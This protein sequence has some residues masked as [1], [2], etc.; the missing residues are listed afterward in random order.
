VQTTELL[1]AQLPPWQVSVSVQALPSLQ[2]SVFAS[3]VQPLPGSQ[4]SVVQTLPSSHTVVAPGRHAPPEQASPTVH[5]L[6]SVQE[7]PS[8]FDGLPHVPVRLSHVPTS[9]HW[10][11]AVQTTGLLP[12]HAA[13]WQVSVCVQ[14]LPSSQASVF[15]TNLQPLPVSHESVVQ[16]LPSVHVAAPGAFT[17]PFA[18]SQESSVHALPSSHWIAVPAW[19]LPPL[20]V[21][22]PV[23]LLPSSQARLLNAFLQPVVVEQES[24]VHGFPSSQV[25]PVPLHAPSLH[26]SSSVQ[27][28]PSSHTASVGMWI[29]PFDPLQKSA[30][31]PSLSSQFAAPP[32]WHA[33]F[34]HVSFWVHAMPSSQG[35]LLTGKLQPDSARQPLLVHGCASSHQSALPPAPHTP[36]AHVSPTVHALPSLQN[37]LLATCVQPLCGRQESVVQIWPSSHG[38]MATAGRHTPS[39]QLSPVVQVLPSLHGDRLT[40]NVQPLIAW[41]KSVVHGLPSLQAVVSPGRQTPPLQ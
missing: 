33:P 21:S 31:Q 19:Q 26:Q 14:A 38:A 10:S 7:L 2:P 16:T 39:W 5:A 15:A 1:P 20:Q 30:V 3:N 11:L 29:Q 41:H 34:T 13:L 9:W 4:V 8:D 37:V 12:L 6:P 36:C 23:H 32:A 17:Q 28:L 24:V 18:L 27:G 22:P 35:P 40:A 25:V